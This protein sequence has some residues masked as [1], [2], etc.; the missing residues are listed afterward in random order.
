[1]DSIASSREDFLAHAQA[2]LCAITDPSTTGS[3]AGAAAREWNNRTAAALR[4]CALRGHRTVALF[5]A[6]TH[7]KALGDT[8]REP[9]VRIICI[10]DDAAH[11]GQTLWGYPVFTVEQAQSL[12]IDAVIL[13]GNSVEHL[14][15]D[16]AEPFRQRG[17]P[18]IRLYTRDAEP[19]AAPS[20][21]RVAAAA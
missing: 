21:S 14:L 20:R 12:P 9:P 17:I 18:V 13:S 1:M 11:P 2:A 7:T 8:L 16:R 4:D 3:L 10:I 6:G 5:G 19:A 15:W